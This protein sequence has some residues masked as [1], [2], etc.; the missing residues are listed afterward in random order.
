MCQ[1]CLIYKLWKMS[2][3]NYKTLIQDIW[4]EDEKYKLWLSRAS[5]SYSAKCKVCSKVISVAGQGIK[6]LDT[7]AKGT[8][9]I[10][11]FSNSS[12]GKIPF[13]SSTNTVIASE[14]ENAVK[15]KANT[16]CVSYGK[17]INKAS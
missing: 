17:L 9:H 2:G 8:K 6:A 15:S 13:T 1:Y 12:T 5:D 7:H 4:L 14:P 16:N 10:Q 3:K 11:R